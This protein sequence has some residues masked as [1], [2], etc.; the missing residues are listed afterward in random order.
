[1]AVPLRPNRTETG[2]TGFGRYRNVSSQPDGPSALRVF[3]RH[4][5]E[6]GRT[7]RDIELQAC[8]ITGTLDLGRMSS[9]IG[10]NIRMQGLPLH[11]IVRRHEHRHSD[12]R[13]VVSELPLRP[14][15]AL[16]C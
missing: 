15:R 9:P 11:R 13:A 14:C 6:T 4:A 5:G 12:G 8:D 2:S 10:S 3:A 7:G 16:Q 1:M